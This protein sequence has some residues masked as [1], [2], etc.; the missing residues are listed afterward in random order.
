MWDCIVKGWDWLG[1]NAG[2]VQTFIGVIALS[3]AVL[4]YFK[5]LKQIKISDMQTNLTID[6]MTKYNNERVFELRL[7]LKIRI[8]EHFKT[9]MELQ[10]ACND[11][12]LRLQELSVDTKTNHPS[13]FEAVDVMIKGFRDSISSTHDLISEKVSE[14]SSHIKSIGV[15]SD[16]SF[17]EEIL[18]KVEQNQDIYNSKMREI[19][20]INSTVNN[21]WLPMKF[22]VNEAILRKN[23]IG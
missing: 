8:N 7:R 2:Q 3:F 5:V 6:Q 17:I 13:N 20:N 21:I 1:A 22:G 9:L 11:L 10:D 12:S 16:L 14:N 4:A 19:K 18:D 23:N 15:T